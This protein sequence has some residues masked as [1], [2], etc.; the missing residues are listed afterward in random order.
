MDSK[1]SINTAQNVNIE[2]KIAGIGD[3]FIALLIDYLVFFGIGIFFYIIIEFAF[4]DAS[5]GSY[6]FYA[7]L[8]FISFLY[9]FILELVFKGQ[10]FG[11]KYREIR[12]VK[13]NGQEAGPLQ[14]LIRNLI[15]PIDS[16]YGVGLIVV[17]FTKRFQRIGDLAAGTI[18]IKLD[19]PIDLEDTVFKEIES[20]Y[21]PV[22]NKIEVL[23]IDEK[24]IE[25]IKEVLQKPNDEL[26]WD[27][28]KLMADSMKSKMGITDSKMNNLDFLKSILKEFRY[29][30][31]H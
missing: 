3:R 14:Y 23:K 13:D 17:F 2:V 18:V 9:H 25:I 21:K 24:D 22:F 1:Y 16:I 29:H 11:K 19:G 6:I 7:I 4:E 30:H 8:L 15:R 20:D 31:L 28:V 26:N 5:D 12:T 27:L 10:S